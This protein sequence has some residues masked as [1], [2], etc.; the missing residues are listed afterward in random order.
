MRDRA[1]EQE[2]AILEQKLVDE[3]NT[4]TLER[5][6]KSL[7]CSDVT[8][9]QTISELRDRCTVLQVFRQAPMILRHQ[10]VPSGCLTASCANNTSTSH[11]RRREMKIVGSCM[12]PRNISCRLFKQRRMQRSS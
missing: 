10:L 7:E 2:H 11:C 1:A 3:Q 4:R 6:Q 9:R 12:P 5:L 8:A